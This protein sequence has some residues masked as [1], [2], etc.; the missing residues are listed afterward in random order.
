MSGISSKA[1]SIA[2]NKIKYNAKEEQ[3]QEFSDGSG[4]ELL[5]YGARMYDPQMG[6]WQVLDPLSDKYYLLSP[7]SYCVNNPIKY[8]DPDGQ[9]IK[10]AIKNTYS[11]TSTPKT[12]HDLGGNFL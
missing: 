7:Y 11:G 2:P 10:P 3:R 12:H 1:A 6:R 8:I 9:D 5:D 4:L